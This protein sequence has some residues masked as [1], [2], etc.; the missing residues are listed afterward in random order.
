M[1]QEVSV[2]KPCEGSVVGRLLGQVVAVDGESDGPTNPHIRQGG[3]GLQNLEVVQFEVRLVH[4]DPP[5]FHLP[6]QVL[7]GDGVRV[8]R[9][10]HQQIQRAVGQSGQPIFLRPHRDV[11]DGFQRRSTLPPVVV[12]TGQQHAGWR[13]L[14]PDEWACSNLRFAAILDLGFEIDAPQEVPS[15]HDVLRE[16]DPGD[17]PVDLD[18]VDEQHRLF[19]GVGPERPGE[20]L[21]GGGPPALG[22]ARTR[23]EVDSRRD[24]ELDRVQVDHGCLRCPVLDVAVRMSSLNGLSDRTSNHPTDAEEAV[25]FARAVQGPEVADSENVSRRVGLWSN[26]PPSDPG[27]HDQQCRGQVQ[28]RPSRTDLGFDGPVDGWALQA[29]VCREEREKGHLLGDVL[30]RARAHRFDAALDSPHD[31]VEDR[32]ADAN[33]IH[34]RQRLQSGSDVDGVAEQVVPVDHHVSDVHADAD[35]D[36]VAGTGLLVVLAESALC[37]QRAVHGGDTALKLDHVGVADGLDQATLVVLDGGVHQAV[38]DLE[39]L[40]RALFV[41]AHPG[42]EPLDV[43]E[44]DGGELAS[45]HAR[46]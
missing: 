12:V 9:D 35:V 37:G 36:L 5:V 13:V 17:V 40:E 39:E 14:A 38:V 28:R 7:G 26:A 29:R 31:L 8:L 2:E 10:R 46:L 25:R 32:L 22:H 34:G 45:R 4:G 15:E 30:H 43:R 1:A 23:G 16:L 20:I 3:T 33:A 6:L 21:D 41:R 42:R 44:Q 24:G 27:D 19:F 18:R 11:L